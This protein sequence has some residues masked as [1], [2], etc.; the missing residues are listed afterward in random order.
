MKEGRRSFLKKRTKKLF[1]SGPP[2]VSNKIV[3]GQKF[4]AELAPR[5]W[6]GEAATAESGRPI[7]FKKATARLGAT[8]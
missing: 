4:F 5:W 7:W 3:S 1:C 8:S 2:G 6:R